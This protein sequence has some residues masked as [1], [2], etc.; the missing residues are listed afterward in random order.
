MSCSC[1]YC[2]KDDYPGNRKVCS[3]RTTL[4][5]PW[6]TPTEKNSGNLREKIVLHI[7]LF[8][9][10]TDSFKAIDFLLHKL[11]IKREEVAQITYRDGGWPGKIRITL[12]NG[13]EKSISLG[14]PIWISFHGIISF[15]PISCLQCDDLTNELADISVGDPWLPE[16]I[17]E[18][19]IGKSIVIS[20]SDTSE[21]LLEQAR[22]TGYIKIQPI[23]P[24]DVIRSQKTFLG[25]KKI[26][27]KSRAHIL[28]ILHGGENTLEMYGEDTIL[29]RILAVFI[30]A[31][32][33]FSSLPILKFIP[34]KILCAYVSYFNDVNALLIK[35]Q[36]SRNKEHF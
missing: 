16:I 28:K 13:S 15:S 6:S 10:H 8:C 23:P 29:G 36:F 22:L 2:T 18:E 1:K 33:Y 34:T 25:F 11:N 3:S 30:I 14:D 27:I 4:S 24:S 21:T 12:K 20:R 26:S 5:Y 31:N 17:A 19:K 9:S 32:Y 35:K 7:G